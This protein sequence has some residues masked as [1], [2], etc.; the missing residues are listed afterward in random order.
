MYADSSIST[1]T[2][3]INPENRNTENGREQVINM[4]SSSKS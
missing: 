3:F 1:G 2:P 4:I